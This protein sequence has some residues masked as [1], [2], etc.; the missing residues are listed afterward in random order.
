MEQQARARADVQ[1][2]GEAGGDNDQCRDH[3]GNGVKERRMLRDV[4]HVLVLGE[5]RAVDDHT[6]SG[7]GQREERLPHR[8]DPDHRVG[9]SLPARGE[10]E[11]VTLRRVRQQ[12]HAHRQNEEDE[13]K[14]RHHDLVGLFDAVCAE[15][16][17]QQRADDHDDVIGNDRVGRAGEGSEPRGGVRRHECAEEGVRQRLENVGHD[18]SVADGDAHGARQRQPAEQSAGLARAPAARGPGIFIGTQR[19]GRRAAAHRKLRR[20]ADV[21][22]NE[23]EQ[24]VDQQKGPAAVAAQLVGKAPYVCHTDRRADRGQNKAPAAG[25]AL[26]VFRVLHGVLPLGRPHPG[27]AA[28]FLP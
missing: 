11:K 28:R 5:V 27:K 20:Q 22:E 8:P 2:V 25:K 17:R 10:H 6:A 1:S 9:Q 14:E 18:D 19:A 26:C 21:A 4:H 23:H 16:E 15:E 12:R 13:E 24:Q 3:G 7:D